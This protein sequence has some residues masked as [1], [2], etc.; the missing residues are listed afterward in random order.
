MTSE[1][2]LIPNY[3]SKAKEDISFLFYSLDLVGLLLP[4]HA[5]R[6]DNRHSRRPIRLSRRRHVR[7]SNSQRRLS[8]RFG[9]ELARRV[10]L[11]L[12][13]HGRRGIRFGLSELHSNRIETLATSRS[14]VA[15]ER[16]RYIGNG[17]RNG[18]LRSNRLRHHQSVDLARL[19]SLHWRRLRFHVDPHVYFLYRRCGDGGGSVQA[20][21][22]RS[23][24]V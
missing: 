13:H 3:N 4:Q 9:D 16:S 23:I 7:L 8:R 17:R 12:R 5:L 19:S 6:L 10:H 1:I 15:S 14:S 20:K 24:S 11:S 2:L 22:L 18:R 21:I